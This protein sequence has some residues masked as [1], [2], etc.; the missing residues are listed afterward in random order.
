MENQLTP[1]KKKKSAQNP[2]EPEQQFNEVAPEMR[3]IQVPVPVGQG[4][5]QA[6]SISSITSM[7]NSEL[8]TS[9]NT[10]FDYKLLIII[11]VLLLFFSSSVY[12]EGLRKFIPDALVNRD[13]PSYL[14]STVVAIIGTVIFFLVVFFKKN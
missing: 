6:P 9:G 8:F 4:Q 3:E 12:V 13:L 5:G 7:F 2:Q 14:T 1:I 11:F 10:S